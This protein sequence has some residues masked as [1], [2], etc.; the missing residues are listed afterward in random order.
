MG[1]QTELLRSRSHFLEAGLVCTFAIG[2]IAN[3]GFEAGLGDRLQGGG[4]GGGEGPAR[5]GRFGGALNDSEG[6]V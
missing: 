2:T 6:S 4:G 3:N 5:R 1:L